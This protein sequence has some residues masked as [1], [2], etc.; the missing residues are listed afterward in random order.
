MLA[1]LSRYRDGVAR[2]LQELHSYLAGIHSIKLN[3]RLHRALSLVDWLCDCPERRRKEHFFVDENNK[4]RDKSL[5]SKYLDGEDEEL[6]D[7]LQEEENKR[8]GAVA[9]GEEQPSS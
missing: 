6:V 4:I 7:R 9:Q 1:D 3:F 8:L 5:W 2:A